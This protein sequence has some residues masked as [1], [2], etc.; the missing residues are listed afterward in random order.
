MTQTDIILNHLQTL[1]KITQAEAMWRYGI[2][3]LG[4]RIFDLRERGY[5]IVKDMEKSTNRYGK[6]VR[7]AAYWL[8][9]D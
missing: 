3:R 7:Y 9:E 5:R 8:K 6:P 2:M 4:A 1:G